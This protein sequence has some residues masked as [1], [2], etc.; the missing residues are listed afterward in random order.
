MSDKRKVLY[1]DMQDEVVTGRDLVIGLSV[2]LVFGVVGF[3]L[4]WIAL[5]I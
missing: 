1:S 2:G 4:L 5:I 3:G